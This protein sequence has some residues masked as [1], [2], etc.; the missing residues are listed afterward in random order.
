M[1]ATSPWCLLSF[2]NFWIRGAG[3]IIWDT[4]EYCDDP[5]LG[6]QASC[7]YIGACQR[8]PEGIGRKKNL[9]MGQ[10]DRPSL[11]TALEYW[12]KWRRKGSV[13]IGRNE[14]IHSTSSQ[15]R[16]DTHRLIP[17]IETIQTRFVTVS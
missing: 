3:D 16:S 7:L 5:G 4:R 2:L 15:T 10:N 8:K 17:G 14:F 9:Q 6:V 13:A 11:K 12:P 1:A